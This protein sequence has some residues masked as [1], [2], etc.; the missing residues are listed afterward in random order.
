MRLVTFAPHWLITTIKARGARHNPN[1]KH[2][3]LFVKKEMHAVRQVKLPL[4]YLNAE[5]LQEG[6]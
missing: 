3:L 4:L 6:S 2:G 5:I 1:V